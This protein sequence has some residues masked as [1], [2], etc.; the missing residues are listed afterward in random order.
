MASNL[1]PY[2]DRKCPIYD[3]II[4][5]ELCYE[6]AMCM[7]GLFKISSVPESTEIIFDF[8]KAKNICNK[9]PYADME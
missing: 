8:E 7:Q 2:D 9:C 5:G 4:D 3:K 6:T 1:T